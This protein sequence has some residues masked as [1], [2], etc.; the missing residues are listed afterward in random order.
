LKVFFCEY[1]R[2]VTIKVTPSDPRGASMD[3]HKRHMEPKGNAYVTPH[4]CN[5]PEAP[6]WSPE[7]DKW[8]PNGRPK[9]PKAAQGSPKTTEDKPKE[10][11]ET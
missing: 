5:A 1:D 3:P 10:P 2:K 6:Q 4:R 8:S 7:G 11:K 9:A